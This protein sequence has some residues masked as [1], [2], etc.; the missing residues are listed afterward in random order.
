MTA[1]T[2]RERLQALESILTTVGRCCPGNGW[3]LTLAERLHAVAEDHAL[4]EG[5][6][7]LASSA[8]GDEVLVLLADAVREKRDL[9]EQLKDHAELQAA[10]PKAGDH[11]GAK[12]KGHKG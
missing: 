2:M 11:H 1:D 7:V 8:K 5:L 10:E 12:T 6:G 4:C 9:R 3:A